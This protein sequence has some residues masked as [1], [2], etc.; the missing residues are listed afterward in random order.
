MD[1]ESGK[2]VTVIAI[3]ELESGRLQ[4]GVRTAERPG[5]DSRDEVSCCS[6]GSERT[7]RCCHLITLAHAEYSLHFKVPGDT[8]SKIALPLGD[9]GHNLIM[10]IRGS[11]SR[12]CRGRR[13]SNNLAYGLLLSPTGDRLKD[14]DTQY[15][16]RRR[17]VASEGRRVVA[18]SC[19][20]STARLH[21]SPVGRMESFRSWSSHLFRGRPGGRRHVRSAGRLSD[22]LMW[23]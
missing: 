5:V 13:A 11:L 14:V 10:L 18:P 22:T 7:H 1:D 6:T 19:P 23:S 12:S 8:P 4:T 2:S 21:R 16:H 20:R 17:R 3:D 9:P 15:H